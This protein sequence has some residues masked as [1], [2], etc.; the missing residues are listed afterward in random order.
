MNVC[1]QLNPYKLDY[2]GRIS[3][4][5]SD[6]PIAE[7]DMLEVTVPMNRAPRVPFKFKEAMVQYSIRLERGRF[8]CG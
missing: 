7:T 3:S 8:G 5:T 1:K 6:D 4:E 2:G